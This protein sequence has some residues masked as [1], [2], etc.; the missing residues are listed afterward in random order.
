[1]PI[2]WPTSLL[3]T[4]LAVELL[5]EIVF[6]AREAAWP[7]IRAELDL[8]YLQIGLLLT[9]PGLLSNLIEPPIALLGDVWRRKALILGGG[10]VFVAALGLLAASPGFLALL[11][12]FILLYPANA[13]FV[14]LSQASLMDSAP[15]RHVQNMARW[16]A[17]GW[18]GTVLGPLVVAAAV[19][20]GLGW[21]S[22]FLG[23]AAVALVVVLFVGRARLHTP[24]R[25]EEQP[26]ER[27]PRM[28][29]ALDALRALGRPSV[30]RWLVLLQLSDLMLDKLNSFVAL[31]VVDVA[32]GSEAQGALSLSLWAGAGLVGQLA[33]IPILE[34]VRPLAYLRV[35]A[36]AALVLFPLFL[37]APDLSVKLGVLG[38]LGLLTAGWYA[39]L[40]G[41]LYSALP[42]RSGTAL[43]LGSVA[44]IVGSQVPLALGAAASF[45]GLGV[46]MWVLLA[47]PIGLLVGLARERSAKASGAG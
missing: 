4:L 20:L 22:V 11:A 25:A 23:F 19:M 12:A 15:A 5:D 36:F 17:A 33:L 1:M 28:Q 46:A 47:A 30:F 43:A 13:A 8:S 21:R 32:G 9:L 35:S 39:V 10:V 24:N 14:N 44:D 16:T 3:L 38:L 34:R 18:V 7:L 45:W 6:S 29:V 27:R 41:A 42:G 37:I 40:Q 2:R 26:G 31:Y